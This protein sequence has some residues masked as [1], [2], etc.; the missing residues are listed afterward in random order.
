MCL[1]DMCLST[2]SKEYEFVNYKCLLDKGLPAVVAVRRIIL[3]M[4]MSE[5]SNDALSTGLN[6]RVRL[7]NILNPQSTA[8]LLILC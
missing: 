8:W 3:A 2:N 1:S 7:L 4:E 6:L 5:K